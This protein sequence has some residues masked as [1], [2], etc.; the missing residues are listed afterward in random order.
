MYEKLWWDISPAM[1]LKVIFIP[2]ILVINCIPHHI[3]KY[4]Y[5][6]QK[7]TCGNSLYLLAQ[8]I[9]LRSFAVSS[10]TH[11]AILPTHACSYMWHCVYVSACTCIHM[12]G[13][14]CWISSSIAFRLR[15]WVTASHWASSSLIQLDWLA[16]EHLI[17]NWFHLSSARIRNGC[18]HPLLFICVLGIWTQFLMTEPSVSSYPLS[19]IFY[20]NRFMSHIAFC[21][22]LL[23]F[24]TVFLKFLDIVACIGLHCSST[25]N[26]TGPN[27]TYLME[28]ILN[29]FAFGWCAPQIFMCNVIYIYGHV[30]V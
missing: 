10:I 21:V 9:K 7:T 13:N 28:V 1:H 15:L 29:I 30:F 25:L 19:W 18:C 5:G 8:G 2:F 22:W 14:Q 6:T 4:V 26:T 16:G 11:W 20:R 24:S 23:S 27:E 3:P 12:C 17:S